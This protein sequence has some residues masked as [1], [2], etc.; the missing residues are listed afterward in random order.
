MENLESLDLESVYLDFYETKHLLHK[1]VH[2]SREEV[3]K[4]LERIA[5]ARK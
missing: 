4:V 5:I 2:A 3:S 1:A